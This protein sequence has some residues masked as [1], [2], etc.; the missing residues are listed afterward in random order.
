MFIHFT[1]QAKYLKILKIIYGMRLQSNSNSI[2]V[3]FILIP[4]HSN[5]LQFIL[6]GTQSRCHS[7]AISHLPFTTTH[8]PS[9]RGHEFPGTGDPK[10]QLV[11][12]CFLSVL[13]AQCEIAHIHFRNS[14][15]FLRPVSIERSVELG[16]T[17]ILGHWIQPA[18]TTIQSRTANPKG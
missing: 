13:F 1:V 12:G 5:Q 7:V 2:R 17:G 10:M 6:V 3:Q 9:K 16:K 11:L 8:F 4:T 14:K 18:T 15:N